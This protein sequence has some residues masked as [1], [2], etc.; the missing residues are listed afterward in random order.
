MF[1]SF[2]LIPTLDAKANITLPA[3]LAGTKVNPDL[4]ELVISTLGI[5][6]RLT[7]L[8]SQLSGG[9]QQ[10]VALAR[11]LVG[12]PAIIV[13]DEPTGNLDSAATDEILDLLQSAVKKLGQTVIMVTH[14][15]DV[16]LRSD[17]VIVVRDGKISADITEPTAQR[18]AQVA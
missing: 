4:Y 5:G 2:N 3:A 18:I 13:A 16:A 14:E 15:R 9:Q 10:R 6:D 1:Q 17:R 8:P 7:H 11:A 12:A